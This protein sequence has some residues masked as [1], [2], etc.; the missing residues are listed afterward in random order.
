[1]RIVIDIPER[2]IA[3]AKACPVPLAIKGVKW[4]ESCLGDRAKQTGV[5]VI[6]HGGT[7]KYVGQTGSPSM[8]FGMRLRRE[9]QQTASS[10][11]HI[12]P[13]LALLTVPPDI[14]VSFFSGEDIEKL[15]IPEGVTLNGFEK[16]EI[17]ETAAIHAYQPDFQRHHEKRVGNHL[18]KLEIPEHA[19]E[20]MMSILKQTPR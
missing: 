18:K 17:F 8:S 3:I 14:M 15:V 11:R 13:K 5:Y 9:F 2:E 12:Y 10:D 1:M 16:I 6:H 7:I 4:K 19:R 20:A